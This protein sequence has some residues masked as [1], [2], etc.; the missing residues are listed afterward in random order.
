MFVMQTVHK[1]DEYMDTREII[2]AV[3]ADSVKREEKT[4][5]TNSK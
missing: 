1:D 3:I 5:T 2:Y 4:S